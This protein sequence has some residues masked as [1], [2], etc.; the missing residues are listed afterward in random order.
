MREYTDAQRPNTLL[1]T[2]GEM[3]LLFVRVTDD[4]YAVEVNG[5]RSPIRTTRVTTWDTGGVHTYDPE[6]QQGQTVNIDGI[7]YARELGAE[8]ELEKP[9]G[10]KLEFADNIGHYRQWT[11]AT[12]IITIEPS[13]LVNI[14][15]RVTEE[16]GSYY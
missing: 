2:F 9:S 8:C 1:L 5:M 13:G 7:I 6:I 4:Q 14:D 3:H 12:I 16:D 11:Y 10:I 15:E